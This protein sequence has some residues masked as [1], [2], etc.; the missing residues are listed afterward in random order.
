MCEEKRHNYK[1]SHILF[2][3]SF[4]FQFCSPST[5]CLSHL[6]LCR[7]MCIK[8]AW[9][10]IFGLRFIWNIVEM[11]WLYL[12]TSCKI[13]FLCFFPFHRCKSSSFFLFSPTGVNAFVVLEL[14]VFFLN[15]MRTK[16][17]STFL[18]NIDHENI[19]QSH[20]TMNDWTK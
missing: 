19:Q 15:R 10:F 11:E 16:P 12:F 9:R 3:F 2:P 1:Y 20:C 17:N 6:C 18:K 5:K 7:Y 4:I 14:N 8:T 13:S